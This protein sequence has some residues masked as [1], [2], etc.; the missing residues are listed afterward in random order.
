LSEKLNLSV[1]EFDIKNN[2]AYSYYLIN[3]D[4]LLYSRGKLVA[5]NKYPLEKFDS[6][7]ERHVNMTWSGKVNRAD[8][9]E[10]IPNIDIMEKDIMYIP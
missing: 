8:K 4:V 10:I 2:T 1:V 3:L 5:V 9:I 7:E 6:G